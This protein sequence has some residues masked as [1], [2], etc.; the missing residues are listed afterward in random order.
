M[1]LLLLG[2]SCD[3]VCATGR[4]C[5]VLVG[6][7]THTL[8]IYIYIF[9]YIYVYM[10][11][12]IDEHT[13]TSGHEHTYTRI[14]P[15]YVCSSIYIYIYTPTSVCVFTRGHEHTYT[16]IILVGKVLRLYVWHTRWLQLVGSL[17]LYVSFAEYSLFYRALSQK[18]PI[19]LRSLLTGLC[20]LT[21]HSIDRSRG[22]FVGKNTHAIQVHT[23][24]HT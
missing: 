20:H 8:Y 10:Y 24:T 9:I 19:L 13:Y 16:H 1:P 14:V 12:Y 23:Q 4:S 6:T 22:V 11:I 5:G 3:C 18:R 21:C 15:V 7:N 2:E 17:K